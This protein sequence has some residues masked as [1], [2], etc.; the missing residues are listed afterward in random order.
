MSLTCRPFADDCIISCSIESKYDCICLQNDLNHFSQ[1]NNL[2]RIKVNITKR[3][4]IHS[5]AVD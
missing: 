5:T 4:V 2:W 3:A 1:W